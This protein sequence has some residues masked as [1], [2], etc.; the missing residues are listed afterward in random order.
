MA[1]P[2]SEAALPSSLEAPVDGPLR[3]R[4]VTPMRLS[5]QHFA[6]YRAYL[7]GIADTQ[8]HAIYGEAGTD[9]RLTRKRIEVIRETLT[10]AAKRRRDSAAMR[11]LRL[12]PERLGTGSEAASSIIVGAADNPV[13]AAAAAS[14][15]DNATAAHAADKRR[16]HRNARLRRQQAEALTRLETALAELP[17]LDHAI[18][19]WFDPALATRLAN[20]GIVTFEDLFGVIRHKRQRWYMAV[21]RLGKVGAQRIT[22]WLQLHASTL[23]SL[24]PSA[25]VPRRQM[26][27]DHPALQRAV[28]CGIVPLEALEVPNLLDGSAGLNRA[29][30]PRHQQ[31]I[32]T[33]LA[34]IEG[35]LSTRTNSPHTARAYRREAE[36]LLLWAIVA[37]GK[38]LSSLNTLDCAEYIGTFLADP[39]PAE[40]WVGKRAVERYDPAW[41]PFAGP[42][43]LRS[44]TTAQ[45]I[46]HS[47]CSWLVGQQYLLSNPFSGLQRATTPTAIDVRGRSL[48]HA[49]WQYVLQATS[50]I[51]HDR[52]TLRN[53]FALLLAYATGL[54]RSELAAATTGALTRKGLDGTLDDA[55]LLN[56][57]GKGGKARVVPMPAALTHMLGD[58]LI[59]R[60]LPRDPELCPDDTPLIYHVRT[61]G[62]LVPDHLWAVYKGIFARAAALL[63]PELAGAARDLE[64]AS[65]HWLR[66]S[67]ANHALD[68]G[69]DL[70]DVQ[71]TL[72]HASLATVTIYLSTDNVRRYNASEAFFNDAL[73]RASPDSEE[74]I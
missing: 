61:G 69:M 42:L 5:L 38:P 14:S 17:Q 65:T 22:D 46:L 2:F 15:Q 37:K 73:Q 52:A 66:H 44:R 60:G 70:R 31:H 9:V 40:R 21:P 39:Q 72:G 30:L 43:S 57:I 20:A 58:T 71:A 11:L 1:L 63:P 74:Q 35:W 55:W 53:Y 25:L 27:N 24:S 23:A 4:I 50:R 64:S 34:A 29:P 16:Q 68:A 47:L 45:N 54:R 8:L 33:D 3:A 18:D 6:L 26:G 12:T 49:Q 67:H 36:R 51:E 62:S 10:A 59:A 7:D 41:R 19:G 56:T 28:Q 13:P 48:T 32:N